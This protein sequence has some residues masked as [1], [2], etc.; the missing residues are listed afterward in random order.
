MRTLCQQCAS[1]HKIRYAT[2]TFSVQRIMAFY[3]F[4]LPLRGFKTARS[5]QHTVRHNT[6]TTESKTMLEI[7]NAR[8]STN[9]K[10]LFENLSL[11]VANGSICCITGESGCG[12]TSLLRTILG[13]QCLEE[14][15]VSIDGEL[16][17]PSSAETFRKDTAYLPQDLSLPAEWVSE[18]VA[19][20]FQ[21]RLNRNISFTKQRLFE[22]WQLL[23]LPRELYDRKT[24]E[25]S[26][27]ERQRAM[28][29]VCGL[30][31]KRLVL[32]DEPTSALDGS[33]SALVASYLRRLA[34]KGAAVVAVSHDMQLASTC[35]T[36]IVIGK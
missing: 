17:T 10:P 22:E 29:A 9:G 31:D 18:M 16:L 11:T 30:L 2:T 25:L 15:F 14:G 23:G 35:D 28:L 21:L 12:K 19:Y 4:C 36:R 7:R 27:G 3:I 8:L 24:G 5:L 32:V 1:F 20:L 33:A 6:Q 34:S 26:G 13:F